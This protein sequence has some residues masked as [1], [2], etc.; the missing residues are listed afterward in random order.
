MKDRVTLEQ[1]FKLLGL[2]EVSY[3]PWGNGHAY[4]QWLSQLDPDNISYDRLG[5][6]IHIRT[7]G[8][9]YFAWT[10]WAR[11]KV[12]LDFQ[13]MPGKL[14]WFFIQTMNLIE[15]YIYDRLMGEEERGRYYRLDYTQPLPDGYVGDLWMSERLPLEHLLSDSMHI[16]LRRLV[17]EE[18]VRR[19]G[20]HPEIGDVFN[21]IIANSDWLQQEISSRFPGSPIPDGN[22]ASSRLWDYARRTMKGKISIE[23]I[24]SVCNS[25]DVWQDKAESIIKELQKAGGDNAIAS[26]ELDNIMASALDG[27]LGGYLNQVTRHDVTDIIRRIR[28]GKEKEILEIDMD[29]QFEANGEGIT[30][31]FL[32]T[33][34]FEDN[35]ILNQD[36]GRSEYKI[37]E[38]EEQ[39]EQ[40]EQIF[41]GAKLTARQR[42]VYEMREKEDLPYKEI[43]Y[44]LCITCDNARRIHHDADKKVKNFLRK[45]P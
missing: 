13:S 16:V 41:R 4:L 11:A 12:C 2:K 18:Y 30:G 27:K 14:I 34:L 6:W 35:V 36:L 1:A 42:Q 26:L 45:S 5:F 17:S 29:T 7:C 21:Y 22:K 31:L 32:D 39:R 8:T 23:Q 40:L 33:T 3:D 43:G 15:G 24:R 37:A 25:D 9:L 19:K 20:E 44:R 38:E 28:R 10:Y